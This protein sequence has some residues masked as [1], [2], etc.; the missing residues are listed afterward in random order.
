MYV[1]VALY[2]FIKV[3]DA[4]AFIATIGMKITGFNYR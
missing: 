3:P 2:Q 1:V 4:R